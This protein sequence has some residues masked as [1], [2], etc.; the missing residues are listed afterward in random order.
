M[1][2]YKAAAKIQRW[3]RKRQGYTQMLHRMAARIQ[4]AYRGHVVRDAVAAWKSECA[5]LCIQTMW[6]MYK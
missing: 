3:V 4:A 5:A 2:F 1:K 6:R